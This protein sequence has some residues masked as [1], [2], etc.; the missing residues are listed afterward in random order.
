MVADILKV[1][2]G[3]GGTTGV[4]LIL[5]EIMREQVTPAPSEVRSIAADRLKKP[6]VRTRIFLIRPCALN[7]VMAVA[8]SYRQNIIQM[9]DE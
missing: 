1:Y 2:I 4:K 9:P 3:N 5:R 7:P 8:W 6:T